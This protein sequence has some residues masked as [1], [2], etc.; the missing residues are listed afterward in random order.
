MCGASTSIRNDHK[1]VYFPAYSSDVVNWWLVFL[2]F[3]VN[4]LFGNLSFVYVNS[5]NC[6]VRLSSWDGGG[7]LWWGSP[8]IHGLSGLNLA[9]QC[10]LW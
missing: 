7:V 1:W 9:L 10:H 2:D 8:L 5:I 4:C 6:I 3:V